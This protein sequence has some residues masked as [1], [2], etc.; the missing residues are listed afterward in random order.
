MTSFED[1]VLTTLLLCYL[2]ATCDRTI[3]FYFETR[4]CRIRIGAL[5]DFTA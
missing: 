3:I 4:Y 2:L 1:V 5:A